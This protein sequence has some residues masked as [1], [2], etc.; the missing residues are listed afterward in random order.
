[1]MKVNLLNRDTVIN[2]C[3]DLAEEEQQQLLRE[4]KKQQDKQ[5]EKQQQQQQQQEQQ[6]QARKVGS[7]KTT[8][9]ALMEKMQ[10]KQETPG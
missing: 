9:P 6:Q 10:I 1:L 4:Q 8:S 3:F 5:K 2:D 7:G